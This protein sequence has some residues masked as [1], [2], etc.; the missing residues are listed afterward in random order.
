MLAGCKSR[1]SQLVDQLDASVSWLATVETV[2]QRWADN[3][4]PVRFAER[5]LEEARD[6]LTQ[7]KQASAAHAASATI[8]VLRRRDRAAVPAALTAVRAAR[9]SLEKQLDAAKKSQ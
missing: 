8:D 9:E 3:R 5:T 6:A 7:A 4:V 1:E 2:A